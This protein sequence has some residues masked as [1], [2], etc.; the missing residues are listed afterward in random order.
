MKWIALHLTCCGGLVL[1][2]LVGANVGLTLGA[3]LDLWPL[4]L[5]GVL[6]LAAGIYYYVRWC[7]SH[8]MEDRW[9]LACDTPKGFRPRGGG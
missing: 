1:I 4:V 7:R 8:V 3:L 9:R 2:I 5:V 6:L